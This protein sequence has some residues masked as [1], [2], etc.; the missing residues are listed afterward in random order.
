MAEWAADLLRRRITEG[1][2][3]PGTRLSEEELVADLQVSRNT[4]R[5]SFRLLTHE[6]L[7]VHLLHRGVFVPELD[8]ADVHDLYRLR[9]MLECDAVRT[10]PSLQP[11]RLRPLYNAVDTAEA[12]AAQG[13]WMD[14]GTANMEFHRALVALAGSPRVDEVVRRLLAEMRLAFHGVDAPQ[15]LFE[16][17]IARNREIADL[18]AAQETGRAA[19]RLSE[20]LRDSEHRLVAAYRERATAAGE[21]A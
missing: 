16:P 21:R 2:L 19:D 9:H 17:F 5:E 15:D 6:G 7:L 3:R 1:A 11:G 14:V 10:L 18:I 20:Y 13:S 8:Q 12:A 4:L